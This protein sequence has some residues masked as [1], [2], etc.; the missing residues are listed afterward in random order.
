MNYSHV[1]SLMINIILNFKK[2]FPNSSQ[3]VTIFLFLKFNGIL[4]LI[5][6]FEHK[7]KS[8]L[9]TYNLF[10][11]FT[12]YAGLSRP[13]LNPIPYIYLCSLIYFI[14]LV[15]LFLCLIIF[16]KHGLMDCKKQAK[17]KNKYNPKLC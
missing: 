10:H 7:Y 14:V 9:T 13:K 3:F 2:K 1:K 5:N 4:S 15:P 12:F 11:S 17:K 16:F 6:P 8:S